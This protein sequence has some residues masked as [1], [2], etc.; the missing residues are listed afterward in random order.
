MLEPPDAAQF[1]LA[2]CDLADRKDA[3]LRGA[4]IT[5]LRSRAGSG[6]LN[7]TYLL[8]R[9]AGY[10]SVSAITRIAASLS[11][12]FEWPKATSLLPKGS[13]AT[14]TS[15]S[16][17]PS[18]SHASAS[19][20]PQSIQPLA[21]RRRLAYRLSSDTLDLE[22]EP[23]GI[24][25]D[26]SKL[27]QLA[28]GSNILSYSLI[29]QA[30]DLRARL[31]EGARQVPWYVVVDGHVDR[32]LDIGGLRVLTARERTR[33]VAAFA[34]SNDAFRR[35]LRDVVRQFNTS[36]DD[37]TLDSILVSLSELLDS[38]LLVSAARQVRRHRRPPR[39]GHPWTDG[40]SQAPARHR[41][42]RL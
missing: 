4:H 42:V 9:N 8:T 36:V 33:D 12:R 3:K 24:L 40:R 34:R 5:V 11:K 30:E 19:G 14:C 23:G 32:D 1:L 39:Q 21:N 15:Q 37:E 18:G 29:H 38:G 28:V 7:W 20:Q 41:T 2:C 25:A 10:N 6:A 26:Y 16:T 13:C 35:S 22:P 27:A 31:R 17:G